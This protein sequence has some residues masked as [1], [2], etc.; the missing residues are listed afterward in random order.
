MLRLWLLYFALLLMAA[1][2][3]AQVKFF[4]RLS[5]PAAQVG[6]PVELSFVLEG[7]RMGAAG[8]KPPSLSNADFEIQGPSTSN[9]FSYING[10]TN[11]VQAY[12]YLLIPKREGKFSIGAA[13][14]TTSSGKSLQTQPL[15][16]QV[17]KGNS[18]LNSGSG[19]GDEVFL[20]L[21]PNRKELVVGEQLIVDVKIYTQVNLSQIAI[22]RMP[23]FT[24]GAATHLLKNNYRQTAT[25]NY[26]GRYYTTSILQRIALFPQKAGDFTLSPANVRVG[27]EVT[28]HSTFLRQ[29]VPY[30]LSSNSVDIKVGELPNA[31]KNFQG[32]VGRYRMDVFTDKNNIPS[33][34]AVRLVVRIIGQ[35]DVKQI[36]PPTIEGSEYFDVAEPNVREEIQEIG[37]GMGG[38]KEFTYVLLPRA[39][40]EFKL[41]PQFVYYH[42]EERG[43]RTIDSSLSLIVT[44]GKVKLPDAAALN[45]KQLEAQDDTAVTASNLSPAA[46]QAVANLAPLHHS[47]WIG[48]W[49]FWLL[50]L[51]PLV[52]MLVFALG[53]WLLAWWRRQ[54]A[55][56]PRVFNP[57]LVEQL[58]EAKAALDAGDARNFAR[59]LAHQGRQYLG[60]FFHLPAHQWTWEFLAPQLQHLGSGTCQ[61][62]KALFEQLDQAAYAG[63]SLAQPAAIYQQM[64]DFLSTLRPAPAPEH[65]ESF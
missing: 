19:L 60:E 64:L 39:I 3:Q 44:P 37:E 16:I 12:T 51:L 52:G 36:L 11:I 2:L 56:K 20:R 13:Q 55:A 49:S 1:P 45:L 29:V 23:E 10:K 43:F 27:K 17:S 63:Q 62:A 48:S 53:P 18:N 46:A 58:A 59:L 26:N 22:N 50:V 25:E 33:E 30:N 65:E 9:S 42:V 15:T 40:G 31:P 6:E 35:G 54:Q 32:A 24:G 34:G 41:R 4:A 38:V 47:S 5:A 61:Q 7:E 28:N 21:V 57:S 8:L 14:V